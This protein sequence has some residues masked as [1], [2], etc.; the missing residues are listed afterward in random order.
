MYYHFLKPR[1]QAVEKEL[2]PHDF[3]PF[4]ANNLQ[5]CLLPIKQTQ[6]LGPTPSLPSSL[7]FF[8]F[9]LQY[10]IGF[11]IHQHASAMGIHVFPILNPPPTSLMSDSL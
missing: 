5:S 6:C 7:F 3:C 11:A 2:D 1:A 10:C 8:F 9:T 4:K